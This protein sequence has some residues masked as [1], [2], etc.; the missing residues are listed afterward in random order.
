MK[1]REVSRENPHQIAIEMAMFEAFCR[2]IR[3]E[4]EIGKKTKVESVERVLRENQILSE[5]R[6]GSHAL[7]SGIGITDI[8]WLHSFFLL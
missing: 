7:P 3:E 6:V 4:E 1:L 2:V 8:G 5:F